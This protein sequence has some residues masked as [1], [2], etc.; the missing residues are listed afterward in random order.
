MDEAELLRGYQQWQRVQS[1]EWVAQS[2]KKRKTKGNKQVQST[3]NQ[4]LSKDND[5]YCV[6]KN[7]NSP[8]IMLH[9]FGFIMAGQINRRKRKP[10]KHEKTY[11]N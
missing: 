6:I 11:F 2:R 8:D 4:S 3:K 10:L 5:F 1:A 7:A 9:I